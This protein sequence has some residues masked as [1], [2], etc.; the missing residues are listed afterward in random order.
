MTFL[1]MNQEVLTFQDIERSQTLLLGQRFLGLKDLYKES[2]EFNSMIIFTVFFSY[3]F[4]YFTIKYFLIFVKKFD[5]K[6]F[7]I[8]RILLSILLFGIIYF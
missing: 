8:Y 2:V 1:E 3:F 5:L 7:V 6:L 4:S